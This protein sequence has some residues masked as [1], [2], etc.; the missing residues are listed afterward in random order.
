MYNWI[1]KYMNKTF[2]SCK[3]V[4]PTW[5]LK[6]VDSKFLSSTWNCYFVCVFVSHGSRNCGYFP[7]QQKEESYPTVNTLPQVGGRRAVAC[8]CVWGGWKKDLADKNTITTEKNRAYPFSRSRCSGGV[9]EWKQWGAVILQGTRTLDPA[10]APA[11]I[12][13]DDVRGRWLSRGS[14]RERGKVLW[15]WGFPAPHCLPDNLSS[16][17]NED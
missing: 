9:K 12:R 13:G 4:K 8:V 1:F 6:M 15:A 5:H 7:P 16:P 2:L 17:E 3:W 14:A 10:S 11:L